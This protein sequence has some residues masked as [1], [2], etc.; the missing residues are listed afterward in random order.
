VTK[1]VRLLRQLSLV[2]RAQ[3]E[4]A[5]E[6]KALS[7]LTNIEVAHL[8][9]MG[10][11][12]QYRARELADFSKSVTKD[13][14]ELITYTEN[15]GAAIEETRRLLLAELPNLRQEWTRIEAD[16]GNALAVVDSRLTQLSGTPV[17]FKTWVEEIARQIAG[18]VAAIQAHDIARQQIEH[19][20]EALAHI[21]AHMLDDGCSQNGVTAKLPR[22][23]AG[24][25]IQIYQLKGIKETVAN[26]ASQIRTCTGG[27]LNVSASDVVGIGPT[28]LAQAKEVSSQ[29]A[30]IELLESKSQ[31][32][33][34]RLHRA[35]G[36]LS[37]LAQL[38]TDHLQ[39]SKSVRD[40]LQ[41]LTFNSIIEAN[42]L[43]TQADAILAI[44]KSIK[45][46]AAEWG[47]VTD[48][49]GQAREEIMNLVKQTN[50]VIAAFSEASNER[51]REAQVETRAAL[52]NLRTAAT[53]A[54]RQ[55]QEMNGAIEKMQTKIAAVGRSGNLL[56]AC[57]GQVDG[58]LAE[59]ETVTRQ[60]EMDQPGV[61]EQYDAAEVEQLFS[62]SYTT[63]IER[64]VLRA[65]L[66][67]TALPMAQQTFAGNSVELF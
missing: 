45:G 64:D 26:W 14:Q 35:L 42:R 9:T 47:R 12:F 57:R 6:T 37:N 40:R 2:T 10:A 3:G 67:G 44:A 58:V 30:Q 31:T 39:K 62:A 36:G 11:G 48:Q 32:Y 23:Y 54:A 60:L 15:R 20:G 25:I 16:L 66:R 49:S 43:G 41:L 27:I 22:A 59:I 38:V 52:D 61:R 7:V 33:S 1:E 5:M 24:L 13:I 19:V 50:E 18:V 17:H 8:G 4:I 28:V 21:S 34:D 46:I 63:E 51:L 29:L 55:A 56:D 65:A 53:F